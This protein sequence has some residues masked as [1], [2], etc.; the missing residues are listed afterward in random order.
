MTC[1]RCHATNA[2]KNA[3]TPKSG[4][5]SQTLE[6][7]DPRLA[8]ALLQLIAVPSAVSHREVARQY[9]RLRVLDK[10]HEHYEHAIALDR[11]DAVSHEATA[12]IWRDWGTP[13]LGLGAAYRAVHYAPQSASGANT[14]GTILQAL[15]NLPEA[16][17]WTHYWKGGGPLEGYRQLDYVL[18]GKAL[19][20]RVRK[21]RIARD[22]PSILA[23]VAQRGEAHRGKMRRTPANVE[24]I[25]GLGGLL[26]TEVVA[27]PIMHDQRAIGI[28]YGDN[29]EHRAPIDSMTGLEIFLS[30]AGYAFGNAVFAS[31]RAGRR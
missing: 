7:S 16:E 26:P 29:A 21:L 20:A 31:E 30:Q 8:A 12:R 22:Q 1:P 17:R 14:L 19:D 6:S 15:A 3:G 27:L 9:W 10:V 13:H 23:D 4:S 25:D 2:P 24:L 28:L 11:T 18:L 5:F